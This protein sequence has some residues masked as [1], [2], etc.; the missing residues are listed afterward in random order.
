MTTI[1][2]AAAINQLAYAAQTY[3]EAGVSVVTVAGKRAD[4]A[5]KLH[6]AAADGTPA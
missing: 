6:K 3:L 5:W 2:E 1:L 4:V